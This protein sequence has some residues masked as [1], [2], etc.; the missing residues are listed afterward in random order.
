MPLHVPELMPGCQIGP[1]WCLAP[2]TWRSKFYA[3]TTKYQHTCQPALALRVDSKGKT[4]VVPK[5][6]ICCTST[7]VQ[8]R[9]DGLFEDADKYDH[10]RFL[11][12]RSEDRKAKFTFIGFGGG[13][14]GCMGTNFAY[15][16]IKTVRCAARDCGY[17]CC[18]SD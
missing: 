5:G 17:L 15:L 13:R 18:R 10:T 11:P 1:A 6:D 12:P 16:Q 4:F 2:A 14:H 8:H 9:L 3:T 7:C